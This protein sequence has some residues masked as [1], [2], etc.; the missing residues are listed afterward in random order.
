MQRQQVFH[1]ILENE[2]EKTLFSRGFWLWILKTLEE[3]SN[4]K[5]KGALK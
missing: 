1:K 5:S 4:K 2:A 3:K